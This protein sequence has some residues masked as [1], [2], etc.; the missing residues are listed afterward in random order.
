MV[1][2]ALFAIDIGNSCVDI[3]YFERGTL[4]WKEYFPSTPESME[5]VCQRA[6]DW[7]ID[8]DVIIAAVVPSLC[9]LLA[10]LLENALAQK[11]ILVEHFKTRLMPLLV[12]NPVSVGVDRLVNCFGAMRLYGRPAIVVSLGTATTF[13]VDSPEGSYLGGAIA[14]GVRISLEAL[15]Q[16]T[17]LLPP[18]KL[19][20]P[21]K[22]IATNTIGHIESGIYYGTVSMIEGMVKRIRTTLGAAAPVI[23]T[24]G[25]SSEVAAEGVFDYHEPELTLKGLLAVYLS[26]QQ[27]GFGQAG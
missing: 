14:P 8:K 24:G 5:I 1:K 7:K 9:D 23:G 6:L 17:A 10:T 2:E 22:L 18:V 21:A 19:R 20:K 25:L 26:H 27:Q 12:D 3:G 13:E 16:R 4:V 11:P 15:S